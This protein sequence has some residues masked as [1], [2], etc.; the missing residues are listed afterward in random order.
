MIYKKNKCPKDIPSSRV[1]GLQHSTE[2]KRNNLLCNCIIKS[3]YASCA[4]GNFKNDYVDLCALKSVIKQGCRLLDFEMYSLNGDAVVAISTTSSHNE[5]G[6]YNSIELSKVLNY[7]N[8]HALSTYAKSTQSCPNPNDPLILN[9]RMKT[10]IKDIYNKMA[11]EISTIFSSSL[12]SNHYSLEN[13]DETVSPENNIWTNLKLNDV[14]GKVIIMVDVI[15]KN[16]RD[17]RLYEI[18]NVVSN[19]GIYTNMIRNNDV[20]YS[21]EGNYYT[22]A[23]YSKM[24]IVLPSIHYKPVNYDSKKCVS[25]GIQICCMCFQKKDKWLD[26]YNKLFDDEHSA[27]IPKN[28]FNT[29]VVKYEQTN[30]AVQAAA[31]A[32]VEEE[33]QV[34]ANIGMGKFMED[35]SIGIN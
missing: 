12:L 1:V 34:H 3:S 9:F 30:S 15:D 6:S 21:T 10:S 26:D 8:E 2:E 16:L 27:F 25:L 17:S 35:V 24:T 20:D 32:S 33:I 4:L 19:S 13:N 11:S 31:S 14:M 5:K 28:K 22:G 23:N 29:N 18:V 7:V